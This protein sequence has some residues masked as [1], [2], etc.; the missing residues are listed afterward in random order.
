[1]SPKSLAAIRSLCPP[2]TALLLD[3]AMVDGVPIVVER[4][5]ESELAASGF[6]G[7]LQTGA[8]NGSKSA[9][10]SISDA[11][12]AMA[13]E[14]YILSQNAYT[15]ARALDTATV[16]TK[17]SAGASYVTGATKKGL[18]RLA[19]RLKKATSTSGS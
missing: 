18:G 19:R 13:A 3:G 14:G 7:A 16:T 17:V 9:F 11:L 2:D 8:G 4:M 12:A 1:M 5:D 6:E 15:K 10:A